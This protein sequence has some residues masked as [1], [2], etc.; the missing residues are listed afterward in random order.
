MTLRTSAL[1]AAL[2]LASA[3]LQPVQARRVPV[4]P[5]PLCQ[6][7]G[8]DARQTDGN[9][10]SGTRWRISY[11][12]SDDEPARSYT[13]RLLA[14]GRMINAHPNDSTPDNDRWESKGHEVKL[15]FNDNY[16]VYTGVLSSDG[17][18]LEGRAVNT[19][20]KKWLWSAKRLSSCPSVSR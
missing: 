2:L 16:A 18:R 4:R 14:G 19:Q 8:A 15:R 5:D 11:E 12:A 6:Q 10:L 9:P 1:L 17:N 3:A 13:L 7:G 20:G